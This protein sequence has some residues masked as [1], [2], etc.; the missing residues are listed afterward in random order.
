MSI[1]VI[2]NGAQGKMGLLACETLQ[3]HPDF[4]LVGQLSRHD[5]LRAAIAAA[6]ADVVVDLTRADCAYDNSLAIIDSG[7]HPVIGTSGLLPA[8]M[9]ELTR[10]CAEKKL[11]GIIVPNF[12]IGAVL[13]MQFAA[14]AARF[15]PD[16]EIIESHHQHKFDAP[17]GTAMKTAELIA[18]ARKNE[19]EIHPEH[20][21]LTGARGGTHHG[22]H[23]HSLRLPGV[24]A[25]QE[26]IFGS[27]GET[28]TLSHNSIDRISFMPG[29]V[30]CCQKVSSLQGLY[31]GMEHLLER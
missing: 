4:E 17:S 5:N 9:T 6:R 29:I 10:L 28:L 3:Q 27:T 16:V 26:V 15:L 19:A 20:E 21:L 24:V 12:S 11:G 7:A 14:A 30:L 1:R 13:M 22:I 31:Y 18:A 23:V 2:V 8:Q 25:K